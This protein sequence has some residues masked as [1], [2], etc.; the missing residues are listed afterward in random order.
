MSFVPSHRPLPDGTFSTRPDNKQFV[1]SQIVE[2]HENGIQVYLV[3][4]FRHPSTL[5][6]R[7][8]AETYLENF[9][10]IVLEWADIAQQYGVALFS[11]GNEL[12]KPFPR[13]LVAIWLHDIIPKI[14]ERYHGLTIAKLKD[15]F[16]MDFSGYDY[17]G[18]TNIGLENPGGVR[19]QVELAKKYAERDGARGVIISE[20]GWDVRFDEGQGVGE[21]KQAKTIDQVFQESWGEV[22]GYFIVSWLLPGYSVKGRPAEQVIKQWFTA[23][24]GEPPTTTPE[25]EATSETRPLSERFTGCSGSGPVNFEHSPMRF[26]DFSVILPYGLVV[27]AHVTPIDHMYFSMRDRSL[28]RDSY[29][30]RAIQD[31]VIYSL[32][33]RDINVDTG[34]PKE[35]EW[36]MDIAHTCTFHSYFDLLT[37][38][39]PSL[40]AEWKKTDGGRTG[41][42]SGIPVKAGQV[43]GRIGDQT[44]DFGVYDYE[45]VLQG[46]IFA[47]HY[48]REPWKVHTVDPFPYFPPAIREVFLERN[49]RKVEPLAGKI[50][51]DI[52]GALSGNWFE[53][54]TNW[55]AGVDAAR[56]WDG[57]LSVAPDY[58]DPTRWIFSIGHWPG[59]H[60]G[61][62]AASYLILDADPNPQTFSVADGVVKYELEYKHYCSF[63][64]P[65]RC[66]LQWEG[67]SRLIAQHMTENVPEPIVGVV[68]LQMI[69]DRLLKAEAFP[70]KMAPEIEDFT[71]AAKLYE[72]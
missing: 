57:H 2:A 17:V 12:D 5:P 70:G 48:D 61:S 24:A 7:S 44:L 60:D 67:K 54:D 55:Y 39:E 4:S 22:D 51:H 33:P 8:L 13:D 16:D 26:E 29:E 31:G 71:V 23:A 40:L 45:T 56:Y 49:L 53:K 10:P 32:Q 63:D 27:G 66:G 59:K 28:G 41:R 69:E 62:G 38:L 25:L 21:E 47:E 3:P 6:D 68:L 72:R 46:F 43:V 30:V 15:V 19:E 52:D 18:F 64:E 42:W 65:K 9:T 50:D 36:R 58:L 14:K 20:F 1:I 37:S 11:P 35:R 34:Q